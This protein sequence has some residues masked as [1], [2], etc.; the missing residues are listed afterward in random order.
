MDSGGISQQPLFFF[1][2]F[3]F[4]RR[5]DKLLPCGLLGA[6]IN[7]TRKV[8]SLYTILYFNL[9]AAIFLLIQSS[10][11]WFKFPAGMI[12]KIL[13]TKGLY[14][15]KLWFFGFDVISSDFSFKVCSNPCTFYAVYDDLWHDPLHISFVFCHIFM[16]AG[17]ISPWLAYKLHEKGRDKLSKVTILF[18]FFLCDIN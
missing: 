15:F 11:T 6:A 10:I 16:G 7:Q 3:P 12:K 1:V 14:S 18:S 5:P 17:S 9:L 2:F 8:N 13:Y 4:D